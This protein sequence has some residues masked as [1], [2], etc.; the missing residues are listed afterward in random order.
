[1]GLMKS[2]RD[3]EKLADRE[4]AGDALDKLQLVK[5][6]KKQE[7]L[8]K[9]EEL[10]GQISVNTQALSPEK[11]AE[12]EFTESLA[13]SAPQ[14]PSMIPREI[15]VD[16]EELPSQAESHEDRS[17]Q[18]RKL[19]KELREIEDLQQGGQ[20]LRKNQVWKIE[21]KSECEQRLRELCS[22][23]T[24]TEPPR[25]EAQRVVDLV[26]AESGQVKLPRRR[27]SRLQIS[28]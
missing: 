24:S 1:M 28:A 5:L 6:N 20:E 25:A 15:H 27:W 10:Q 23:D 18:I 8:Q 26:A 19:R 9:L 3:I 17:K 22:N 13:V 14:D 2:L 4:R 7:L 21:K 11:S 16:T 12:I